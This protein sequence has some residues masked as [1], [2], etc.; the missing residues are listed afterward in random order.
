[1]SP[2]DCLAVILL[3]V[4]S[5]ILYH[6][7]WTSR[8]KPEL[9]IRKSLTSQPAVIE[10]AVVSFT[11]DQIINLPNTFQMV[12]PNRPGATIALYYVISEFLP[13]TVP[14]TISTD[15]SLYLSFDNTSLTNPGSA[16]AGNPDLM[17][18]IGATTPNTYYWFINTFNAS[19]T[20]DNFGKN[21]YLFVAHDTGFP[22]PMIGGGGNGTL[23]LYLA[24][25]Y[26]YLPV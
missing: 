16:V 2:G 7:Y 11:G 23:L 14:Y 26:V 8:R 5:L 24:Y 19:Y 17:T 20:F 1:M 25:S 6:F 10:T 18:Q 22:V 12:L 21:L 13:G 3:I 9:R 15:E 4:L